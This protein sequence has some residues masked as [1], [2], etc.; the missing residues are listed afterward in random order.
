[1][2]VT[3]DPGEALFERYLKANGYDILAYERDLGT[4]K[5]PDYLVRA[6]GY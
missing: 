6:A 4:P 5:R 2:A 1:M 3:S